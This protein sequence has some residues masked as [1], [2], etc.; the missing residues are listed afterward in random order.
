MNVFQVTWVGILPV[1]KI[2]AFPMDLNSTLPRMPLLYC[3]LF[4]SIKPVH[5]S[6]FYILFYT[7]LLMTLFASLDCEL[8]E[9]RTT[10]YLKKNQS[11]MR[12]V[13]QLLIYVTVT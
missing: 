10:S 7:C 2:T 12:Y 6:V 4:S 11:Y 13:L 8:L 3:V 1:F 5:S 9:G